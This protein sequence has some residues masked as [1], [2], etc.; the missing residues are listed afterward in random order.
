MAIPA[1]QLEKV[2]KSYGSIAALREVSLTLEAGKSL[3][4]VGVNGAGKT[5]LLKCLLDFCG[6]DSGSICIFGVDHGQPEARRP[7]S[8]LPERFIPPYYLTGREFLDYV[9]ALQNHPYRADE[10][11]R[12][13]DALDLDRSVLPRPVRT[14]SKGMTQKL[15]LTAC[16]LACRELLV[17]DEPMSGLDPKARA[18]TKR[19]IADW[20]GHGHTLLFTTHSLADV[21]ELCDLVAI[22][23]GGTLRFCGT[24]AQL[25]AR[26]GSH[27]GEQAFLNCIEAPQESG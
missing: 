26:Y 27:Q 10:V 1:L 6:T 24:P 3:A 11:E 18:L 8:Y 16:L 7:L 22:L 14:L 15:G 23:H 9:L 25:L 4:L 13:L 5:T 21:E 2:S 20:R 12:M 19:L 17:L